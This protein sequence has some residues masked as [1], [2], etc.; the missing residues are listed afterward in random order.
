MG[1]RKYTRHFNISMVVIFKSSIFSST[2]CPSPF[3]N[4]FTFDLGRFQYINGYTTPSVF[5][6][7]KK[8]TEIRKAVKY[9]RNLFEKQYK[10]SIYENTNQN[11]IPNRY[12]TRDINACVCSQNPAVWKP[13]INQIFLY[14]AFVTKFI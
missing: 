8:K 1:L 12:L 4:I 2:K 11:W 5:A 7:N 6:K 9:V 13:K 14:S 10:H 3:I